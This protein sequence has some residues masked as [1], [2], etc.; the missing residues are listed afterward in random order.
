MLT[1]S[2]TVF[3]LGRRRLQGDLRAA[4]SA[5]RGCERAGE[6]LGQEHGVTGQGV[7]ALD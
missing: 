3:S 7:M 6:G 5:W 1:E 4:A 2:I